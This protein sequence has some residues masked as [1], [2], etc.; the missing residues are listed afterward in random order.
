MKNKK[1]F[2]VYDSLGRYYYH[3]LFSLI[4]KKKL[5]VVIISAICSN[6]QRKANIKEMTGLI[7]IDFDGD[8]D[9]YEGCKLIVV[10][11]LFHHNS[12]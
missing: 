9:F 8:I 1:N 3:G 11:D 5:P 12:R 7:N 10:V 6:G 4:K 2:K